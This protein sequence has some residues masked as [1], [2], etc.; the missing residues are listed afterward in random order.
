MAQLNSALVISSKSDFENRDSH[1]IYPNSLKY[2]ND[3]NNCCDSLG[4]VPGILRRCLDNLSP[5]PGV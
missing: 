3:D 5:A 1:K 2:T 4:E